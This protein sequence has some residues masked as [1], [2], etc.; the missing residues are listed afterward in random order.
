MYRTYQNNLGMVFFPLVTLKNFSFVYYFSVDFSKNV[1]IRQS[2]QLSKREKVPII[3][4]RY[5][6]REGEIKS[7]VMIICS[8]GMRT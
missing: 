5:P 7:D 1:Y 4:L 2:D 6:G 8:V 3:N